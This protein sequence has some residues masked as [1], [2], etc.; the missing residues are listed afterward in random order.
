MVMR[1]TKD[2]SYLFM[3]SAPPLRGGLIFPKHYHLHTVAVDL[4]GFGGS[5]KPSD[6]EYTIEAFPNI[7]TE[8]M[9]KIGIGEHDGRSDDAR[10]TLVSHSL[11]GYIASN[12]ASAGTIA[13]LWRN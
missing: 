9:G 1:V 4:P 8:F 5:D 6:M 2:T 13:I 11:G 12:I 10:T 3:D 7:I